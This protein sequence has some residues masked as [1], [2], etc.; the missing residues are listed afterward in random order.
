MT[1]NVEIMAPAGSWEALRAAIKAGADS[2][3]FGVGKLNMRARAA[4]NFQIEDLKEIVKICKENNVK[5]YLTVNIVYYDKDIEDMKQVLNEAKSTGVTAVICSDMA[6]IQYASSIGLE[7]HIS[8]QANVSNIEAVKFYS[9]FADVIVLAR[10]LNIEQ[11]KSIHESIIKEN[12]KGPKGNPVEIELFAHGALCV[13]V[14]G[15]CYMSLAQYNHSANRG[16]CLQT[17]RRKYRV[18]DEETGDELVIDNKYVMSPKDLCTI[19]FVDKLIDSG[20]RVLKLEGRGRSP[21]YVYTVTKCYKEAVLAISD[22]TYSEEKIANWI[23]ELE[24]VFNRG[25]WH[26]GYYLGNKL[27]EWSGTYGSKATKKKSFIGQ[28][29]NYY[30]NINIVSLKLETG[31]IQ[32]SDEVLII[33]PTTGV[34]KM[35]ITG[36]RNE[37]SVIEKASKGDTITF[38]VSKKVRKN[39]KVYVLKDAHQ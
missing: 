39:D 24:T 18:I 12:I 3:Y 6:A 26:G 34:I 2:V 22:K 38:P 36:M 21:E 20:V 16:D 15:K 33:G 11:I 37:D 1:S 10:E 4:H 19:G 7:I 31:S 8:T 29:V 13:S 30:D 28:V 23:K 27:G 32:D 14:S 9:K 25:F 17:C 35:K 5:S